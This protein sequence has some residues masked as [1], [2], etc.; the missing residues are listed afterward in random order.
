[1]ELKDFTLIEGKTLSREVRT[2][3]S[4]D[5]GKSEIN[6]DIKEGDHYGDIPATQSS[7]ATAKHPYTLVRHVH[8]S[9]R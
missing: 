4:Y 7:G 1:M 2:I 5:Y 9:K 8:G 6:T 3:I